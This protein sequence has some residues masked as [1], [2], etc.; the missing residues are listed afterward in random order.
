MNKI[1]FIT[2][3]IFGKAMEVETILELNSEKTDL[4]RKKLI[5][6]M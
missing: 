4:S 1:N 6:G 3:D 2:P 5:K